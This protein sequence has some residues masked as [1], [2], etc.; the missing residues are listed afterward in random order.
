MISKRSNNKAGAIE[1]IRFLTSPEIQR[2][3]AA[4]RGYAPTNPEL[5][6]AP[7]VLKS[8]PFFAA[9][10]QVLL[11]GA[12]TRPSTVSGARYDAVSRVYFTMIHEVLEGKIGASRGVDEIDA[13]LRQIM[14][15]QADFPAR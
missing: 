11:Q 2:M 12:V 3:S 7:V 6:G 10:R 8:N 1:L 14:A 13:K 4:T 15:K 5:Y 9:L